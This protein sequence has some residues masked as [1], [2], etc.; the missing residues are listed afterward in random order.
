M[1]TSESIAY[2]AM[3]ADAADLTHEQE[4]DTPAD[5]DINC[6][7]CE[8]RHVLGH[9]DERVAGCPFCV[10]VAQD[11]VENHR[12]A[13]RP[14]DCAVCWQQHCDDQEARGAA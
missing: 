5:M 3:C 11:H 13:E 6:F 14:N 7:S 4:H 2:D 12:R 8:E 9:C 1:S 10:V